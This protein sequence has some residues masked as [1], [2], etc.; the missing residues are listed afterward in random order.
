MIKD[1]TSLELVFRCLVMPPD[2]PSLEQ[3]PSDVFDD[4]HKKETVKS[5]CALD[6]H[7]DELEHHLMCGFFSESCHFV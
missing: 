4:A 5:R 1:N 6:S 2:I 7:F 3:Q